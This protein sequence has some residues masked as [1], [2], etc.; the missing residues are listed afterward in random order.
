MGVTMHC[1]VSLSKTTIIWT[2]CQVRISPTVHLSD[3]STKTLAFNADSNSTL[4]NIPEANFGKLANTIFHFSIP[5]LNN[6]TGYNPNEAAAI[7]IGVIYLVL[8]FALSLR[9]YLSRSWWGLCLPIGVAGKGLFLNIK[10]KHIAHGFIQLSPPVSS[11]GKHPWSMLITS[12]Y[13][14]LLSSLS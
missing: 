14:L 4:S 3:V 5:F 9:L 10:K 1:P 8:F 13:S 7:T 2:I 11:Y 6:P 12:E